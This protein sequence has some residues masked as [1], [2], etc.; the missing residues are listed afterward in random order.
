MIFPTLYKTRRTGATQQFNIGTNDNVITVTFGQ[1]DGKQQRQDTTCFRKNIGRS[2]ETSASEQAVLEAT[3]KWE[4]KQKEGYS[5][6]IEEPSEVLLPMK[7]HTYQEHSHKITFP[8]FVSPKLNG[9]NAE[10]RLLQEPQILSRGGEHYP[11]VESRDAHIF[12]EM[13]KHNITSINGEIYLH[14]QHLQ[15]IQ[16]AVKKPSETKL[17]PIFYAFDIPSFNGNYEDRLEDCLDHLDIDSVA[18]YSAR[19]HE[20]ILKYHKQFIANGYEGTI[21][22]NAN[23]AYEY[24]TRSYDVLKLKDAQDAEFEIETYNIDKNAHPVFVCKTKEGK[25]FN[26]KPKGTDAERREILKLISYYVGEWYTVEFETY[27][28]DG[29]PLKPVGIGLRKCDEHGSPLQ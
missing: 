16:S 3:A 18:I 1:V 9:V 20:D 22:R 10:Y 2:N 7:I 5:L 13:K 11:Y 26:V 4:K 21:I 6:S 12:A 15:D 23:G 28:K 8:C 19:S 24:N 25:R 14:G 29:V 27:S 17:Q